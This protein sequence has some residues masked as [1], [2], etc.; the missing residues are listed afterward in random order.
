MST[1][2]HADNVAAAVL[3]VDRLCGDNEHLTNDELIGRIVEFA[4]NGRQTMQHAIA[5]H[6][7]PL[8][9]DARVIPSH[10]GKEARPVNGLD[11][12]APITT[13]GVFVCIACDR[14]DVDYRSTEARTF[15]VP[16]GTAAVEFRVCPACVNDLNENFPPVFWRD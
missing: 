5:S 10:P 6:H 14:C 15:L 12:D 4:V 3:E 16:A 13:E 9:S 7:Y 2:T 8:Q 11:T 1:Q